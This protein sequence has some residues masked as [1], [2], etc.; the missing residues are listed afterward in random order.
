MRANRYPVDELPVIN[1]TPMVDVM[2]CLLVFFMAATRLY[3]WDE[4]QFRVKLPEVAAAAPLTTAPRDLVLQIRRAGQVAIGP[5]M[6]DL[7]ALTAHLQEAQGRYPA[8]GVV[9]RADAG[10]DYQ[11]LA[12]VLSSCESAHIRSIRLPVRPRPGTASAAVPAP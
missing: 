5:K 9:I 12:D 2:L 1:M 8:Q 7:E 11:A 10:L 6:Y 4:D 3:D